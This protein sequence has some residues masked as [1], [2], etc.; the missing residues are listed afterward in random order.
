MKKLLPV[1]L[2][3]IG[4]AAGT[5][6]GLVFKPSTDPVH[7]E[8]SCGCSDGADVSD[9]ATDD[10]TDDATDHATTAG[11]GHDESDKPVGSRE[12]V[13]LNNQF[14][15]PVVE[16]KKVTSLVVISLSLEVRQG[17]KE[18]VYSREPRLRDALLQAMFA[19]A[20]AGGFHGSFTSGEKMNDLRSSL[21]AAAIRVLGDIATKVLVT[22][23]VRQDV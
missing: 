12:Y 15:V 9:H 1:I 18:T 20:N 8:L 16:A 5:G 3:I 19:H 10:A 7:T 13:K 21:D 4:L 17:R 14:I 11:S 2:A 6:A 22:D 23:I